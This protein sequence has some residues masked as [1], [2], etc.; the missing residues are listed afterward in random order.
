MKKKWEK[1]SRAERRVAVAKD[2]IIRIN[3]GRMQAGHGGYI[4]GPGH[5]GGVLSK[6]RANR[7]AKEC[8]VCARGGLMLAKVAK[9]NCAVY[10]GELNDSF[11][12]A[13]NLA[14]CFTEAQLWSIESAYE[15]Y[16]WMSPMSDIADP[17]DRLL[18]ICQNI[19][20]H[21]G[22]FKPMVEYEVELV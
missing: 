19:I 8:V 22:T 5:G 16:N 18:A 9:F 12:T 4:S 7:L 10:V 17:N 15:C 21:K 11:S 14:D 13:R 3:A 6:S 20:D 1:M 2:V